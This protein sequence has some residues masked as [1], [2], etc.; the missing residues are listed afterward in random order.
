MNVAVVRGFVQ[1]ILERFGTKKKEERKK[2]YIEIHSKREI[3]DKIYTFAKF[4]KIK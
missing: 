2:E 4:K 3:K 1:I